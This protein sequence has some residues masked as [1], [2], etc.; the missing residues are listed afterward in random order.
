MLALAALWLGCLFAGLLLADFASGLIHWII[1]RYCEPETPVVGKHFVGLIHEHHRRPLAIFKLSV[2]RR[3]AGFVFLVST[4]FAIFWMLGLL[5]PVTASA[6]VF[7]AFANQIHCWAHRRPKILWPIVRPL[8]RLGLL[9]S[10]RHHALHH[11]PCPNAHYCLITDF[12]NP[13]VDTVNLWQ[14]AE[15]ALMLV[16]VKPKDFVLPNPAYTAA[17]AARL[18]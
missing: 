1:D 4:V 10:A 8:Q 3:N 17:A 2:V 18:T 7:G 15:V 12:V 14:R 16:G 9:Q 13:V 5:N 11:G 6:F